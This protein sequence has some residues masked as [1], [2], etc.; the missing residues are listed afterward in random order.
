MLSKEHAA[1]SNF[2][3][4]LEDF[5]G[6]IASV[7]TEK[8]T[9]PRHP[10]DRAHHVIERWETTKRNNLPSFREIFGEQ[11]GKTFAD[12]RK[13]AFKDSVKTAAPGAIFGRV[14][15]RDMLLCADRRL[16]I[17]LVLRL[18]RRSAEQQ[19]EAQSLRYLNILRVQGVGISL[20]PA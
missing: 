3:D 16:A 12:S 13:D 17:G 20:S 6:T 10:A 9:G 2:R 11:A 1:L 5:A 19:T 18:F 8:R 15:G 7:M 14:S 4:S